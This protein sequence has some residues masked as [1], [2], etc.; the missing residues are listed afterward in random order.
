LECR[1]GEVTYVHRHLLVPHREWRACPQPSALFEVL[2]AARLLI[3]KHQVGMHLGYEGDRLAPLPG[4][5]CGRI[6]LLLGLKASSRCGAV[7]AHSL[8]RRW[9]LQLCQH[10]RRSQ[11]SRV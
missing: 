3:D 4:R 8:G 7:L 1:E 9:V 6:K 10:R 5:S 11:N 2:P